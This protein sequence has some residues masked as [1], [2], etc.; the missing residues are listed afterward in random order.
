MRE[1]DFP[2]LKKKIN[3][4]PLV[5]LDNA[6][7]TQKPSAVI[8]SVSSF[9]KNQ[10]ANPHRGIHSLSREATELY[11]NA[12][13]KVQKFIG[14]G[15]R[16]E[17]IFTSSATEAINLVANSW[18]QTNIKRGDEIVLTEMEHHSNLVPWQMLA[19]SKGAKLKFIPFH[20]SP[21]P[22]YLKRG[23][24]KE[25]AP[26]LN[27]RE[28]K[29]ELDLSKLDKLITK[30]TK[31]LSLVHVSNF[32]G[33]INPIEKI[34]K[35][36]RKAGA[37]VLIDGAQAGGHLKI[38]VRKLNCD[39]YVLSGHKMY[40]PTGIGVLYGKKELLSKMPPYQFGGHMIK[41]VGFDRTTFADLPYKFEAG[42]M[43]V[44][45]AVGLGTAV[46]YLNALGIDRIRN[47]ESGIMK[48]A[49]VAL[50]GISGVRI[51]GPDIKKRGPI[52][53][54]NV[55]GVPAHDLASILDDHGVAI[56][57]GHHCAMPTHAKFGLTASA[58]V[59][60]ALYNE[61]KD[62]QQL[63]KGIKDAKARFNL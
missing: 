54:F 41:K 25:K 34:I 30:K 45:Q 23:T 20:N 7:T 51:Y 12:R 17:I 53:S 47:Y 24:K 37:K 46:D 16:E 50:S 6:A 21:N 43:P 38:D 59:S 31:L 4:H 42:T 61:K 52:I 60:F 11:E 15:S 48:K 35:A 9:Y 44:A 3:G 40:G 32:L 49:F 22:S 58:R 36:A 1:K 26:S 27:L 39:F 29:G 62:I 57:T 8:E 19:K 56:R 18:G 63:I 2:I 5:Y 10:N 28:G 13:D 33:T 55:I 14:A